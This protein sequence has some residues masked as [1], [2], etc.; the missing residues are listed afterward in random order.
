M[1][2]DLACDSRPLLGR[3]PRPG[4]RLLLTKPLGTGVIATAIKFARA[5]AATATNA[6][7]TA[8][9]ASAATSLAPRSMTRPATNAPTPISDV[10]ARYSL[11]PCRSSSKPGTTALAD[12]A[13]TTARAGMRT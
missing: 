7:A 8:G 2:E 3:P 13:K 9:P 6:I 5:D 1:T 10:T 4:D 12:A 11:L